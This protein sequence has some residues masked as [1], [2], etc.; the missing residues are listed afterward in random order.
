[1][2]VES[3]NMA[4]A[5]KTIAQVSL[6]EVLESWIEGFHSK[7]PVS[8]ALVELGLD[9]NGLP[10]ATWDFGTDAEPCLMS[11]SVAVS[12]KEMTVYGMVG[13]LLEILSMPDDDEEFVPVYAK[14]MMQKYGDANYADG[15]DSEV[16]KDGV[17]GDLGEGMLHPK[18]DGQE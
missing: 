2:D 10:A 9:E 8:D 14:A 4:L 15:M 3:K 11:G 1:M 12:R 16:E 5:A 7:I 17:A 6:Q 18:D 13:D